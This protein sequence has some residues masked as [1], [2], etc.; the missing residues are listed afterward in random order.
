MSDFADEKSRL[1]NIAK[2]SIYA[3]GIGSLTIKYCGKVFLRHINEGSIL[4]LGP[5]EG[6]MTDILY[7]KF[8]NDYTIVDGSERFI[9]DL[10]VRYPDIQAV[11]ELF[12]N[13][14]PERKFDNII[15][16]HVLEHVIDPV[17][18]LTLC[19]GWL[20]EQGRIL[21]AVPN[22]NSIHRQAALSMGMIKKLDEFSQK[23]IRHGHRRVFDMDTFMYCFRKSNLNIVKTGGYWLKP[24][25]DKQLED[26][27]T[28]N[29]MDAFFELGEKYPDIAAEIYIVAE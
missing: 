13:F 16:G 8:S 12:E 3:A 11:C 25:S 10:K 15:L 1:E 19:K 5:A 23:D 26:N 4:E 21:T 18:I 9:N 22:R 7:P 20:S 27:W 14:K 2:D 24:L 29:M 17:E 6:V 28:A